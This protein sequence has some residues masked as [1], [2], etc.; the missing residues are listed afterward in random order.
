MYV[1]DT[2]PL[3]ALF[4]NYYPAR[5]PSLW[6]KFDGLVTSGAVVSTRECFRELV[7]GPVESAVQWAS[8]NKHIFA[9]PV[10]DE[11]KFVAQI[12]G[13]P[14]FQQNIEAQKILKGGKNA[15]PFIIAKAA[16]EKR[17]VV[18]MEQFKTN[19]AKIP[20]ICKHFGV[21]CLSLEEF[22]EA[23]GWKF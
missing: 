8:D 16:V 6:T 17:S 7:D 1:F 3:S 19:A 11:G 21:S 14:H 15:D 18:T 10:A 22:M 5:F 12:Y 9:T 4:K 13:V 23:E 2:S 20:N